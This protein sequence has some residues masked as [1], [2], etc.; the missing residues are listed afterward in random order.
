MYGVSVVCASGVCAE[1]SVVCGL[2]LS[3][4][5]SV[6]VCLLNVCRGYSAVCVC[7]CV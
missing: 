1:D 5:V 6:S 3:V 4:C 2:C 7:V